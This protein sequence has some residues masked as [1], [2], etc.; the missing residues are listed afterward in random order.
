LNI[1]AKKMMVKNKVLSSLANFT[2]VWLLYII[3]T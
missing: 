3:N 2:F 1:K